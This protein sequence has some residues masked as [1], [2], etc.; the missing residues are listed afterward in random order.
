MMINQLEIVDVLPVIGGPAMRVIPRTIFN[1]PNPL[2]SFSTPTRSHIITDTI[3]M[4]VA[5]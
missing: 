2:V 5:V 1:K 3:D 4:Y